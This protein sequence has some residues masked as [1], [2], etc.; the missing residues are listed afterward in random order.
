MRHQLT[1]EEIARV[2]DDILWKLNKRL[3]EKGM[4][5]YVSSHE[6]FGIIAEEHNEYLDSVGEN[7]P[8]KQRQELMD[9]AVACIVGIASL[10]SKKM[11]WA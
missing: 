4:G 11:D 3:K 9:I 2:V 7:N 6:T 5:I 1:D 8:E 10:Q